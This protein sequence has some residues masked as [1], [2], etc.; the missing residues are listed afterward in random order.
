MGFVDTV[1]SLKNKADYFIGCSAPN[2]NVGFVGPRLLEILNE[3]QTLEKKGKKIIRDFIRRNNE[4]T[5]PYRT[6]GLLINLRYN[7]EDENMLQEI[8][9]FYEENKDKISFMKIE[10]NTNKYGVFIDFI[11]SVINKMREKRVREKS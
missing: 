4:Y 6:N 9:S 3:K 2:P 11:D 7:K 5:K 1:L 8:Q 10:K